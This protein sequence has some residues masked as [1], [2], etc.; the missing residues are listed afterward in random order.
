M[1]ENNLRLPNLT[2]LP[3][4]MQLN[5]LLLLSSTLEDTMAANLKLPLKLK[6]Q[7]GPS[8]LKELFRHQKTRTE[9]TSGEFNIR[10]CRVVNPSGN[11]FDLER[12]LGLQ[13]RILS[14]MFRF[15]D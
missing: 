14:T 12:S 5:D 13:K 1:Y 7:E 3:M 9:K 4:F 8:R 2:P 11:E 15:L 10:T 6:R